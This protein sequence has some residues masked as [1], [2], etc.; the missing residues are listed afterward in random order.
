MKGSPITIG[1]QDVLPGE[2]K[3]IELE[4]P[5]LYT[6]TNMS[7]PVFVKRGKR[8]GPTMFVSAAIHGDE[9]NGI[10]IVSRLIRSKSITRLRGTL[11]AVPMVN[12]Y[13]VLNQS[14]YLPDRR[15]LNRSFPGSK[16]GS[17]AGRL[18]NL[19]QAMPILTRNVKI[20]IHAKLLGMRVGS[21]FTNEGFTSQPPGIAY[22][23][24]AG[25]G[26]KGDFGPF[27]HLVCPAKGLGYLKDQVYGPIFG[28]VS[29]LGLSLDYIIAWRKKASIRLLIRQ[30][31]PPSR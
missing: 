9:L 29:S 24:P 1:G 28:N 25:V 8:E 11:I 10:E 26:D 14:R 7:I 31:L 15:D 23:S 4:M 12:V 30:R 18:A 21:M 20:G 16:K 5:P 3:K 13:G 22:T 27:M 2:T 17:L 6:A 19:S